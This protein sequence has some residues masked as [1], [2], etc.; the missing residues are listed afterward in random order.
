M[1]PPCGNIPEAEDILAR[2]TPD[3]GGAA[4]SLQELCFLIAATRSILVSPRE[5]W[6]GT[7]VSPRLKRRMEVA[8]RRH[9][10]GLVALLRLASIDTCASPMW[11]RP[12][13][14]YAGGG[15]FVCEVC[16]AL[17]ITG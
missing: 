4:M 9:R 12:Y 1:Q 11:H 14:R 3:C 16:E 13:W 5:L 7:S 10:K 2:H 15:I 8:V 6:A 17:R